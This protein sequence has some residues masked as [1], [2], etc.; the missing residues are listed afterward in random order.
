LHDN[1]FIKNLDYDIRRTEDCLK[2]MNERFEKIKLS[3]MAK[4]KLKECVSPLKMRE[5]R[6]SS[7]VPVFE[8]NLF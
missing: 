7:N 8:S 3:P 1:E 2:E 5:R 6:E 4:M